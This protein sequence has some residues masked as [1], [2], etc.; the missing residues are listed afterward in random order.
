MGKKTATKMVGVADDWG[1]TKPFWCLNCGCGYA[2]VE[3][4]L[5]HYAEAGHGNEST[6]VGSRGLTKKQLAGAFRLMHK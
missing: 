6:S 1:T 3:R 5:A 2:S 4:V